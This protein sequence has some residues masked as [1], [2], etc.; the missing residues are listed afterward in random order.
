MPIS[1]HVD[2]AIELRLVR[3]QGAI[4]AEDLETLSAAFGDTAIFTP[5]FRSLAIF[6]S[7]VDFSGLDRETM[8][9]FEQRVMAAY[10]QFGKVRKRRA[11]VV[12]VSPAAVAQVRAWR[13][14]LEA[15]PGDAPDLMM[16]ASV[17]DAADWLGLSAKTADRIIDRSGFEQVLDTAA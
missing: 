13:D 16:F 10:G 2:S 17:S 6:A 15:Q 11:A 1:V 5:H 4:T 14:R 7:D 9:R 8:A 12:A 3:Y